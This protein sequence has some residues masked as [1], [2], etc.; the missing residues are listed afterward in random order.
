MSF[1]SSFTFAISFA[2]MPE[3]KNTASLLQNWRVKRVSQQRQNAPK[4][5][6]LNIHFQ[7]FSGGDTPGPPFSL[8]GEG[9]KKGKK[10]IGGESPLP[11]LPNPGSAPASISST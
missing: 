3:I 1:Y 11:P 4:C 7:K 5:T 8:G 9:R 2:T 10:K 6:K